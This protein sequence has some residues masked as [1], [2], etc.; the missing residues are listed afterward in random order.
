MHQAP[1]HTSTPEGAARLLVAALEHTWQAICTRH[2]DLPQAVLVVAFRSEG[3]RLHLGLFSP[4][5]ALAPNASSLASW[6]LSRSHGHDYLAWN[7]ELDHHLTLQP[8][9]A[10]GIDHAR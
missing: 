8:N 6:R 9:K 3:K 4:F 5:A 10:G 7:T 1:T 2:P